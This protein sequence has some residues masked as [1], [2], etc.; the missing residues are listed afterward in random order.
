MRCFT[1]SSVHVCIQQGATPHCTAQLCLP[2]SLTLNHAALKV[3]IYLTYFSGLIVF[4]AIAQWSEDR[5]FQGRLHYILRSK[6]AVVQNLCKITLSW[7]QCHSDHKIKQNKYCGQYSLY[8]PL[9]CFRLLLSRDLPFAEICCLL[10]QILTGVQGSFIQPWFYQASLL[11]QLY[12][13]FLVQTC[14][15]HRQWCGEGSL[16]VWCNSCPL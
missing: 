2:A 15:G 10:V 11:E 1:L 14:L 9:M 6:E 12:P 16:W 7:G 4:S 13:L 5:W 8:P 3:T